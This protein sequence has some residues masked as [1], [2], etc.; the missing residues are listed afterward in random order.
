M[1][2]MVL[3]NLGWEERLRT[4]EEVGATTS[5]SY[6]TS[7][8]YGVVQGCPVCVETAYIY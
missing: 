2:R 7:G 1:S 3:I 6:K 5:R 4:V 8:L